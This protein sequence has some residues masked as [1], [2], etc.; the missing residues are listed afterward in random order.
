MIFWNILVLLFSWICIKL[1]IQLNI[2]VYL[3]QW[4]FLGISEYFYKA[5]RTLNYN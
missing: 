4:I 2:N 5:L 3:N 1:L